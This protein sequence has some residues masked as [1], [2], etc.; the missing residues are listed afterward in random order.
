MRCALNLISIRSICSDRAYSPASIAK[1]YLGAMGITPPS[2]KFKLPKH[3]LAAAMQ[4]YYGGRAE[5]RIRHTVVPVVHT[6]FVSEY[7][8][9]N[10]LMGLSRV[11]CAERLEVKEATKDVKAFLER[12]TPEMM[13]QQEPWKDLLFFALIQPSDDILP[14]RTDYNGETTNI[15]VNPLTSEQAD[16]V[17][18]ARSCRI[19]AAKRSASQGPQSVPSRSGRPTIRS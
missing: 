17:R 16:V 3:V 19:Q 9:V 15:G 11:L 18:G 6:D 4:A 2:Q 1:A 10:T 7:P 14:V 12:V 8:T 5:C 13:F